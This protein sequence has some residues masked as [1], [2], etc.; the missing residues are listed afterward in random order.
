MGA[1]TMG[2]QVR[3]HHEAPLS[4]PTLNSPRCSSPMSALQLLLVGTLGH[5]GLINNIKTSFN[6][7]R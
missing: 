1:A 3:G 5:V 2:C 4:V 6:G 7:L